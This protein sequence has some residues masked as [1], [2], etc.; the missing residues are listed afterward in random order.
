MAAPDRLSIVQIASVARAL[1]E[2]SNDVVFIG[3]AIAPLLQTMPVLPR[4]RPTKDVDAIMASTSYRD[5]GS[6]ESRL[7]EL[8]FRPDFT[9]ASHTHRWIS[10]SGIVFDLVPLGDHLASAGGAWDQ[11][12]LD[13]AVTSEIEPGLTIRH[14]SGPGFLA[15]KWAAF[16]DRGKHDP[17]KSED[18]EDILALIA[19]REEILDEFGAAAPAVQERI[20]VGLRWLENHEEYDD[21]LAAYLGHASGYSYVAQ[22]VRDRMRAM[23]A[24]V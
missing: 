17:F 3:G 18:L 14:A 13:T 23:I 5:H 22:L 4:V 2:L 10:P 8:G 15:L 11:L 12:A 19:S 16:W 1:L 9:N 20:I 7:R 21:F 24:S 6:T